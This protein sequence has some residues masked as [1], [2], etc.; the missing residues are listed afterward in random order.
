VA[1]S[2]AGYAATVEKAEAAHSAR[3]TDDFPIHRHECVDRHQKWL[4]DQPNEY[5]RWPAQAGR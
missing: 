5:R 3:F 2:A 4:A 1:R